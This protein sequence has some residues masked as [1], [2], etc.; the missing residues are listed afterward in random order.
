MCERH[1]FNGWD[2][3]LWICKLL[4]PGAS[5]GWAFTAVTLR[6][7]FI[8]RTS[9]T[10]ALSP[11]F[12]P[13]EG[14]SKELVFPPA[15]AWVP[16]LGFLISDAGWIGTGACFRLRACGIW[17]WEEDVV[18]PCWPRMARFCTWFLRQNTKRETR[19][20]NGLS[21]GFFDYVHKNFIC[22]MLEIHLKLVSLIF[23]FMDYCFATYV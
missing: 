19:F 16:W 17:V 7:M 10:A 4:L 9:V 23:I 6:L 21:C 14:L 3:M 2:L 12:P 1:F 22:K 8:A 5:R 11:F 13:S 15:E 18:A 20:T